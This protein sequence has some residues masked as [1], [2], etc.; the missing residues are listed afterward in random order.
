MIKQK[1]FPMNS[2]VANSGRLV[3]LLNLKHNLNIKSHRWKSL[4]ST[5]YKKRL[6]KLIF[7]VDNHIKWYIK[8]KY[9]MP[10][11]SYIKINGGWL[12]IPYNWG[13]NNNWRLL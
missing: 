4:F 10:R 8:R 7:L 6:K 9:N 12:F 2:C 3:E 13:K 1:D 5:K 11:M